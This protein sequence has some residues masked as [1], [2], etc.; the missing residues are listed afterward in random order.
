MANLVAIR[1]PVYTVRSKGINTRA[2]N[3]HTSSSTILCVPSSTSSAPSAAISAGTA[4]TA[5]AA[6]TTRWHK[7]GYLA[8]RV[9]PLTG[10]GSA[11]I[12][13]KKTVTDSTAVQT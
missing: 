7:V 12:S 11:Q 2:A 5:S 9:P 1:N 8:N 3:R 10:S 4:S 6:S 13:S